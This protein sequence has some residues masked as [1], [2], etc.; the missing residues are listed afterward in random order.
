[1]S[2]LKVGGSEFRLCNLGDWSKNTV[3]QV[4]DIVSQEQK[5]LHCIT[6]YFVLLKKPDAKIKLCHLGYQ[7]SGHVSRPSLPE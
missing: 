2:S 6:S 7:P 5:F 4:E 1:V 3:F